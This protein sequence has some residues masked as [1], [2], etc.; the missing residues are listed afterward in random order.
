[1]TLQKILGH[2][3]PQHWGH[4]T[5]HSWS[6]GPSL[7]RRSSYGALGARALFHCS[8]PWEALGSHPASIP[9]Q[10]P[11]AGAANMAPNMAMLFL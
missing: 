10:G 1:M 9:L 2:K 5:T 6:C 8:R 3:G 7:G 11:Q 4:L